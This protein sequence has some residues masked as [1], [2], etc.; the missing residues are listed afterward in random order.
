MTEMRTS[1]PMMAGA[2]RLR[3]NAL[4]QATA[5]LVTCV[6][7]AAVMSA[8]WGDDALPLLILTLGLVLP[9]ALFAGIEAL[10]WKAGYATMLAVVAIILLCA[11]FR[12]R[13]IEDKSIDAQIALRLLALA[14]VGLAAATSFLL[15]GSKGP[16][17]LPAA[18]LAFLL[19]TAL[20]SAWS[21]QPAVSSV[22]T[23]S[24]LAAF[25]FVCAYRRT[26]GRGALIRML[27]VACVALCCLSVLAYVLAPQLG[28]MSDWVNGAF[29]PTSRLSGIFGTANAAGAA[30]G[31]GILL[32]IL[33]ADLSW[34]KPWFYVLLAPMI[35]CLIASNNRMSI[36]AVVVCLLLVWIVTGERVLKTA[37]LV[38]GA[39]C[40]L[41]LM[42]LLGDS[43]LEALS[44][45]GSADEITS[46]T[47]RTRIWAV[48]LDLW[49]QQPLLG[50]GEGSAK[51]ILPIHPMLFKAAAHAHNLY[52]N[53]LMSGGIVGLSLFLVALGAT[54]RR[55]VRNEAYREAALVL[56]PLVYGLTEPAIGGLVSFVALCFYSA[57]ALIFAPPH[58]VVR[59]AAR[60]RTAAVLNFSS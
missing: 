39:G 30:A 16:V 1:L 19:Y 37:L 46:G 52:L 22:E 43:V 26:L 17:I 23:L 3:P 35:F 59:P 51:F 10:R 9:V 48:V 60:P 47:G 44:R 18:W 33:L 53:V 27:L 7:G 14:L 13:E 49:M 4:P 38:L 25:V 58:D 5:L 15:T 29:V 24:N 40:A 6:A 20:T 42:A 50:Y 2:R 12:V 36:V 41:L 55:A 56:F 54:L 32:L 8:L 57:V 45:S 28:R 34:R 11:T 31:L 21:L